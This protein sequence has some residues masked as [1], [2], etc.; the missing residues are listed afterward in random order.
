LSGNSFQTELV[1]QGKRHGQDHGQNT[2]F[3]LAG[4]SEEKNKIFEKKK[5]KKEKKKKR[6][7]EKKK[8]E[9]KKLVCAFFS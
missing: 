9:E 1:D 4:K 2:F 6:K 7:K 8:K 3:K 5:R